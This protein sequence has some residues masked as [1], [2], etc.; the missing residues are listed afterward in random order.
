MPYTAAWTN[1]N[2]QG[3][4]DAGVHTVR[5]P[6]GQEIAAAINRRRLLTYQGEQ[7][8][9]SHLNSS[10]FVKADTIA[11]ASAPPFDDF[12][13]AL[14]TKVLAAPL[15]TRG[16]VPATPAAMDWLWPLA[17]D[18]E[19]KILVSGAGGVESGQVGLFQMLNG[20]DH[21]TDDALT[22]GRTDIRAVHFN[23]LRQAV[24]W[25]RRGRW[26]LPVYFSAG[27]L[28]VLPDTPW[29][30]EGISNNGVDE[31]RSL[32]FAVIRT[33]DSPP[34]GLI[35]VAPRSSSYIELTAEADCTVEVYHCLRPLDFVS[36]PPTWNEYDPD[37][38]AA[39]STPG[40][41]GSGEATA[42]GTMNLTAETPGRLSNAAL[43]SALQAMVDGAQ[44]H[45]LLRRADTGSLTVAVTGSV[46]IEFD[47][48][49][50][51]N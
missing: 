32:G 11:A 15:G 13:T 49:S 2:A 45:F 28:S 17:G 6:D 38:S 39:W 40:G 24:E 35:N 22:G 25:I 5:L 12:R 3:R 51:P 14:A 16:G 48:D 7:N 36:D 21:W 29:I 18:D 47:I 33:G 41:L 50:P 34:Q 9:S 27:I 43:T 10:A 42:I 31:L 37:A 8:F 44:P 4:L 46:S 20:T 30:G 23:E 19:D 26:L 1:A